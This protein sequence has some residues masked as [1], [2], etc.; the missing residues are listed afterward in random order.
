MVSSNAKK[1]L[2]GALTLTRATHGEGMACKPP[3]WS[4]FGSSLSLWNKCPITAY[5]MFPCL[6]IRS[7]RIWQIYK[8]DY[9][10]Y[11]RHVSKSPSG[12]VN[13]SSSLSLSETWHVTQWLSLRTQIFTICPHWSFCK[14]QKSYFYCDSGMYWFFC[15]AGVAWETEGAILSLSEVNPI[16]FNLL[17]GNCG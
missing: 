5:V 11:L 10:S 3:Q 12:W 9:A 2:L 14:Y 7:V 8:A 1:Q 6:S 16:I 15:R 13:S 4:P 17:L